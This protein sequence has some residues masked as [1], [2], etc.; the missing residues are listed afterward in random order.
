[1]KG[2]CSLTLV[3]VHPKCTWAQEPC[4]ECAGRVRSQGCKLEQNI[5]RLLLQVCEE[6]KVLR[7]LK[8]SKG[9]HKECVQGPS[10]KLEVVRRSGGVRPLKT[11]RDIRSL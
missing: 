4:K 10:L 5:K 8:I 7:Y 9:F 6:L 2:S 1:M 3:L 11:F